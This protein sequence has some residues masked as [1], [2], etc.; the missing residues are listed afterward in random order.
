MPRLEQGVHHCIHYSRERE[1]LWILGLGL[2]P[3]RKIKFD[4]YN[5]K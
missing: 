1:V 5:N 3:N 2:G 4:N